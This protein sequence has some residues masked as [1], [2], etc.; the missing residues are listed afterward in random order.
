LAEARGKTR[1]PRAKRES[2]AIGDTATQSKR[3]RRNDALVGQNLI[4]MMLF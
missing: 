4:M 1:K 2:D 3:C